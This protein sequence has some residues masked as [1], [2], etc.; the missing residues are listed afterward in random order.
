M[1]IHVDEEYLV[2]TLSRLVQIN[3]TNPSLSPEGAGEAEIAAYVV[4]ALHEM[5]LEVTAWEV[6]P[7]RWNVVGRLAGSGYGRSLLLN[8]HLDTVGVTGMA[9]PFSGV[10]RDGRLYGRGSQDMKGSLAAMLAAAQALVARG[11]PLDGDLLVTAVADE[12]HSS[13]GADDLVAKGFQATAAIV[14]EPTDLAVCLAHRGFIWYDVETF[15]RAAHGSRYRE[16]IDANMHMGRFLAELGKLE[17]ELR[18]RPSHPLVD[19]PSLH[20]STLHGGTELS[21]Y[22]AHCRLQMERR[23]VPGE[24]V[25]SATAELQAIVDRLSAADPSFRATITPTFSRPPLTVDEDAAIVQVVNRAAANRLGRQP[26]I[27][28]QP[29]WTDAAIFAAA[30]METMLIGPTGHGLHSAEEWVDVASVVDL[31]AI[32]ADTAVSYLTR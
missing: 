1:T 29:F 14:T 19:V 21:V 15:G 31:A 2:S 22:A 16:G 25:A 6:A 17:A 5:G 13:I 18:A 30:G 28:G 7:G 24:T 23:T 8:A 32:L 12:E 20:A 4:G 11:V 26:A 10:V 27:V 3:S 9:E